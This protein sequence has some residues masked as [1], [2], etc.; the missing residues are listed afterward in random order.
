MIKKRV[1]G[2]FASVDVSRRTRKSK[3]SHQINAVIDWTV[4]EKELYK[5]CNRSLEDAASLPIIPWCYS[6]CSCNPGII[7]LR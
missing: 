5:V 7:S 2:S 3:F 6:R 1:P 4:F